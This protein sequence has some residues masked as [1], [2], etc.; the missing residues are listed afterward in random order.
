MC[1]YKVG[2][3]Q[4]ESRFCSLE[5]WKNLQAKASQLQKGVCLEMGWKPG[6]AWNLQKEL[7]P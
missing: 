1:I 3:Q 2:D 5:F 7:D 6:V 4:E